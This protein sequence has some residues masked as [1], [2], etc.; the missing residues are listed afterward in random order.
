MNHSIKIAVIIILFVSIA[1]CLTSCKRK[2]TLPV[3][4]TTNVTGITQTNA[5]SGGNVTS[6]GNA[7]VTSRGVCWNKL[8]N[9]T[10]ANS[11]TSDGNGTGSFT[12]SLTQLT[13]GTN[14][15]VRAYATNSEGTSYGSQVSFSS[16][17]LL[18]A[19]LTTAA[20]TSITQTTAISGGNITS[21]GGGAITARGVCWGKSQNPTTAD[22]KTA[23][24]SGTGTGIFTSN[25]SGLST[26]TKYYIRAYAINIAGTAYGDEKSFTTDQLKDADGNVYSSI[27]IGTQV[28]MKE[29]LKTTHLN[30][31][32]PIPNVTDQAAWVALITQG[33][34]WYN[35]DASNYKATYGALYNWNAVSSGK[36]CPTGWHV[37]TDGDWTTLKTFLGGYSVA[38]GKLKESGTSH[39]SSPNTGATNITGFT[40]L[41]GG[42]RT[43]LG[44]FD[45]IGYF[46]KWWS[47]TGNS[48]V[49]YQL[50]RYDQSNVET[51]NGGPTY[52]H[53]VRCLKD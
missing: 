33:Y 8:E 50:I 28:W 17:P 1:L 40:A 21:D 4:T 51:R 52:G 2:P 24:D 49:D 13:P 9:P 23:D 3:V 6:D 36:L 26:S 15:Y 19:T 37:P 43:D 32:T 46:G 34:C 42:R 39:W 5:T 30:D 7:E 35:N 38:G 25:I 45:A 31:N 20:A 47:F 14:Y 22:S 12:S 18:L 48:T 29:N 27:T 16:N 11:K 10:V 44:V 53:S 41:P